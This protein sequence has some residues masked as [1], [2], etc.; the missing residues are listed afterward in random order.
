MLTYNDLK[1]GVMFVLDGEPHEVLDYEFL[2]MQQRKPVAKT[3]I[4]NLITGKIVERNFHQ[5]ETFADAEID[6][7]PVKFLYSHRDE[8]WFSA[9]DNPGARFLLE[10]DII[11][12][13]AKFLKPNTQVTAVKFSGT[14]INIELPI[15]IDLEVKETPPGIRGDTAQGGTKTAVLE[16]GVTINVPLFVNAGDLVRVNTETGTY[17]ERIEKA[18]Q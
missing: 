12:P 16:S 13:P 15:K 4:K 7:E 2:R 8:F 3:K 17:V 9:P 5:N 11:G 6:K 18:K 1:K 10:R 14:I